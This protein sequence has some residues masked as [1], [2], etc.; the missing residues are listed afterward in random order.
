[1]RQKKFTR[2]VILIFIGLS[3]ILGLSLLL[4]PFSPLVQAQTAPTADGFSPPLG[5]RDGLSYEPR[6]THNNEGQLIETTDY[7]VKNPDLQGDTCFGVSFDQIYHAGED[8]YRADGSSTA[9]AEVTA[10]A[11]GQVAFADPT[12]N[13]PGLVVIIEHTLASGPK[14]YSVYA[15]LDDSSLEVEAG[16]IVS[17]GQ[18]LGE[19]MYQDY[20][21]RYPEYHPS[22]DDSHLHYELRNFYNGRNIYPAHPH[23]GGLIPGRG[24][25]YPE[26]P[27]D[28]PTPEAGYTDPASFIQE[29]LAP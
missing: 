18:R 15:H 29:R 19:V 22:G 20:F 16:Q 25:T 2:E 28:F 13:Y 5:F 8:W 1:M 9:G 6:I 10:V 7:G 21:G 23:C 14:V 4:L 3:A 12:M 24:Y 26:I 11:N 17:R 27:D